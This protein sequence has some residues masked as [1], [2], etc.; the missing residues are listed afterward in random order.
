MATVPPPSLVP[1][2]PGAHNPRMRWR[3][4]LFLPARLLSPAVCLGL[5]A[6]SCAGTRPTTPVLLATEPQGVVVMVNGESSGFVTPCMIGLSLERPHRVDLVLE[7]YVPETRLII[8]GGYEEAILWHEM[9]IG[10]RN[11]RWPLWLNID[12]FFVPVRTKA[13]LQPWRIFVRMKRSVDA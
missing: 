6:S 9:N 13:P 1:L 12:D 7:G 5:I 3:N 8:P 10:H 11:W 2:H 4:A